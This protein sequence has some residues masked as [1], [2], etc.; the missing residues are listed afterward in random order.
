MNQTGRLEDIT[1]ELSRETIIR[2]PDCVI[3]FPFD[4]SY[5]PN[6]QDINNKYLFKKNPVYP[7]NPK[8]RVHHNENNYSSVIVSQEEGRLAIF[9]I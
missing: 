9:F 2:F 5:Q 1:I 3:F 7:P 4:N 8:D 6:N